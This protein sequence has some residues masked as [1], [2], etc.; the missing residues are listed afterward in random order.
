MFLL[1]QAR[2][3]THRLLDGAIAI[4][5]WS[6]HLIGMMAFVLSIRVGYDFLTRQLRCWDHLLPNTLGPPKNNSTV[7][8][9]KYS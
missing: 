6:M 8:H 5:I 9:K 1:R 3:R 2:Q 4:G 7:G